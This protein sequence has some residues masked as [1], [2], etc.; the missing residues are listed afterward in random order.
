M[1]GEASVRLIMICFQTC[2]AMFFVGRHHE[3]ELVAAA[4]EV[5]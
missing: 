4:A 1:A 3:V 2:Q 5:T